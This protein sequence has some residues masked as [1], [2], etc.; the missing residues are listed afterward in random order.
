MAPKLP[1]PPLNAFQPDD[2]CGK[3][4]GKALHSGALDNTNSWVHAKCGCEWVCSTE[5]E[6]RV[7]LPKAEIWII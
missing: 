4:L 2:C 7:W 1:K 5:D 3:A 6:M